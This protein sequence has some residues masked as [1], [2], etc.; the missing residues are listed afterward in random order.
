MADSHLIKPRNDLVMESSIPSTRPSTY[1]RRKQLISA[2]PKPSV[3]HACR[4]SRGLA[5]RGWRLSFAAGRQP[6]K[7]FFDF[8]HDILFIPDGF[9]L[10]KFARILDPVD[11]IVVSRM[12]IDITDLR[13]SDYAH[14]G[15][16]LVW[17]LMKKVPFSHSPGLPKRQLR[18]S[19][20]KRTRT[21]SY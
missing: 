17:L 2:C 18:R 15:F 7:I 21:S 12:A 9:D 16:D 14:G 1:L 19:G 20:G 6:P 10:G 11:C 5:L 13:S 4:A 8:S 3:L